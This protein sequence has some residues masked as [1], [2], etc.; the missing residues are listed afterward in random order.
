MPD[1]P[2]FSV[3]IPAY[4]AVTTLTETIH[5]VQAQTFSG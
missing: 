1:T 5:S 3:T 4:N 2:R